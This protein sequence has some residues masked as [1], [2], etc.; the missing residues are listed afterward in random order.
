M[1]FYF[2]TIYFTLHIFAHRIQAD[3]IDPSPM[4]MIATFNSDTVCYILETTIL[5]YCNHFGVISER[6]SC[7]TPSNIFA[8]TF[9]FLDISM[10]IRDFG[11]RSRSGFIDN[12]AL[13]G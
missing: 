11:S 6:A 13:E 9:N 7:D 3:R 2:F 5:V 12:A 1:I 4:K 8:Y 10:S